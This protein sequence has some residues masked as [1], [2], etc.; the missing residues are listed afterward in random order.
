MPYVFVFIL[1]IIVLL[2]GLSSASQSYASA[3]QAEA[4]IETARAAQIA[5]AGNLVTLVT[6]A[7]VVIAILASIVLIT[8][9]FLRAKTQPA[10]RCV[11]GPNAGWDEF[12]QP[13]A[14]ALLPAVLTM[15]LYQ[16][17][18]EQQHQQTEQFWMMNEPASEIPVLPEN[19]WDM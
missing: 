18:Q 8:W 13:Q 17:V 5:S 9:L 6:V 11:S 1:L 12:P 2:F 3:K 7:L 4:T 14:N 15:L 16:M 10:R 19:T